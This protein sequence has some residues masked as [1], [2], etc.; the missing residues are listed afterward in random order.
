MKKVLVT[1]RHTALAMHTCLEAMAST[2]SSLAE[3]AR[4]QMNDP[5]LQ[6]YLTQL[7]DSCLET[8]IYL[9]KRLEG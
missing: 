2:L 1:N 5:L 7:R 8:V 9:S 3:K 6:V 4:V